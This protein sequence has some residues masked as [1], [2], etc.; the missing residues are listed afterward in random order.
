MGKNCHIALLNYI[1]Y[2]IYCGLPSSLCQ[3]YH[4]LLDLLQ[5]LGLDISTKKL[6]PPDTKIICLGTLFDM[7]NKTLS[8]LDKTVQEIFQ[9]CHSST[10]TELQSLFG[11]L[12]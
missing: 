8:I 11:L 9:V 7:V 6:Y 4:L 1:N 10:R 5:C 3:T 2:L 12:L